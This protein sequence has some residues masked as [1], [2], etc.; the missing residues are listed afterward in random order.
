M[1]SYWKQNAIEL[2]LVE[3]S[4]RDGLL[5]SEKSRRTLSFVLQRLR[6]LRPIITSNNGISRVL[7]RGIF[8]AM[9]FIV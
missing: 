3:G 4:K 5:F 9:N 8:K 6:A 1:K 2:M 7:E